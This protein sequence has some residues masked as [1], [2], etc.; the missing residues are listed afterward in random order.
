MNQKILMDYVAYNRWANQRLLEP[1]QEDDLI[2]PI[3]S[4][5]PSLAQTWLHIWDAEVL[6]LSRL[7]GISLAS[8]PSKSKNF[9]ADNI[10][11]LIADQDQ[12]WLDWITE[13]DDAMLSK[14]Y[15]YTTI[16]GKEY[17]QVIWETVLHCMNHSTYH[18]GQVVT[19][20]HQIGLKNIVPTDFVF[21]KR[22]T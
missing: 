6:W 10:A 16:T 15:K 12:K 7:S 22:S 21:Y 17:E 8:L 13:K 2:L 1:S 20:M 14:N 9:Q 18:R 3:Q 4:S 11:Q 19:I 5:F